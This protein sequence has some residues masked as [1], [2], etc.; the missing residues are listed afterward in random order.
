MMLYIPKI[1]NYLK[2]LTDD[3]VKDFVLIN[4]S[5]CYKPTREKLCSKLNEEQKLTKVIESLYMFV[6][7]PNEVKKYIEMMQSN[8]SD[9]CVH[10]YNF[11]KNDDQKQIKR[12][13]KWVG[14]VS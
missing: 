2:I 1:D 3:E 7:T 14:K 12:I 11:K 13:V 4:F 5:E 8:F 10:H 6:T 9:N